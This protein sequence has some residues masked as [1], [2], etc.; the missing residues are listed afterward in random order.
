MD[1][2]KIIVLFP[3]VCCL[4]FV[5]MVSSCGN[6]DKSAMNPGNTCYVEIIN[7]I[8]TIKTILGNN[9]YG[10]ATFFKNNELNIRSLNYLTEPEEGINYYRAITDL[11][12]DTP[13]NTRKLVIELAGNYTIDS[14]F[15]SV[16]EF[17]YSSKKWN[18][19]SD[20]GFIK[21]TLESTSRAGTDSIRFWQLGYQ[22]SN[23][24]FYTA[25]HR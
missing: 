14:T 19:V 20:Q 18:K 17:K 4:A 9:I 16:R 25:H 5:V 11:G 23:T 15:Y 7:T 8:D 12:K 24:V 2:K 1:Y 22:I 3:L 21:A 6:N 10:K 13:A